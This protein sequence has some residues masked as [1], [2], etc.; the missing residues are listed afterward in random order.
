MPTET[1]VM[2]TIVVAIFAVFMS[3]VAWAE[4][5]TRGLQRR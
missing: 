1:I 5:V 2:L 4:R 3:T